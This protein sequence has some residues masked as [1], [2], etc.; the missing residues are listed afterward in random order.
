LQHGEPSQSHGCDYYLIR[1]G[2]IAA[3]NAFRK[4]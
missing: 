3:K 1:D 4:A 2:K